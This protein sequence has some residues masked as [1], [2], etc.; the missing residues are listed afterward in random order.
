MRLGMICK[1]DW[2]VRRRCLFH[3]WLSILCGVAWAGEDQN[4]PATVSNNKYQ[5]AFAEER[6]LEDVPGTYNYVFE[7]FDK[8]TNDVEY[9]VLDDRRK[10]IEEMHIEMR[11][12]EN[13]RLVIQ[14]K[15]K[16]RPVASTGVH[17]VDVNENKLVDKF[18]CYDP[19]FAP[20]KPV[21]VYEKFYFPHELPAARTTVVL[22]Y[23][24]EKSA[25]DNRLPVEGYAAW[26]KEQVGLPIYPQAYVKAKA[27]VLVK[28]QQE[29][30]CWYMRSSPFLWDT[31]SNS[32]VFL[33]S[34]EK[35]TQ[36]IRVDLAAGLENPK[37]FESPIV[38]SDFIKP[39]LGEE[40]RKIEA[41]LLHTMSVTEIAWDDPNHI[42]VRP[43]KAYY[44]LQEEIRLAIPR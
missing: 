8:E 10:P 32:V 35:N 40:A 12:L 3:V 42:T 27:Y 7:I 33:C 21:L 43:N 1:K 2:S 15:W 39:S 44:A 5:V 19:V 13:E 18:W 38:V 11:L 6:P 28:E 31:D 30:P 36:I 25:A 29:N 41:E 17:I 23:D 34:H 20:T 16:E 24:M 9:L 37:I 14:T 22:V 26:P 4:V